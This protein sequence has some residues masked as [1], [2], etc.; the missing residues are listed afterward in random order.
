MN[1][2]DTAAATAETLVQRLGQRVHSVLLYGSAARDEFLQKRSDINILVLLDRI[3]TSLLRALAPLADEWMRRQI[4]PM[5]IE[6]REWTRAS[7]SFA[8]ELLDMQDAHALLYGPD[9]LDGIRIDPADARLQAERELRGRLIALHNGM[10]RSARRPA[11]LGD[12]LM[13]A[14]PSFVT[15]L[16]TALRL[17]GGAVPRPMLQVI[18]QGTRL[19]DAPDTGFVRALEARRRNGAWPVD[20]NDDVVEQYGA[21]AERTAWFVDSLEGNRQ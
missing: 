13:T 21:A 18:E 11:E 9:P 6:E 15:Y 1:P 14:L 17:T 7:D 4:N 3:D 2:R 10:V 20:L 8:V 16:R 5:L 19:V 12:L